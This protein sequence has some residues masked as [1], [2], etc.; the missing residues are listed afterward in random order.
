MKKGDQRAFE[1][2]EKGE[3][4]FEGQ[5]LDDQLANEQRIRCEEN[6]KPDAQE[7]AD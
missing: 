4:Q 6:R 7:E 3:G 5:T 1:R 2:L